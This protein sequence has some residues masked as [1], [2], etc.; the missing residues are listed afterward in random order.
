MTKQLAL[1]ALGLVAAAP[2]HALTEVSDE[3]I[4]AETLVVRW[5]AKRPVDVLVS[6]APDAAASD[7]TLASAAD[8]DGEHRL[9]VPAGQRRYMLLRER[10]TSKTLRVAERL[11]PLEAGSNFRDIGG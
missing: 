10:G 4:D 5:T 1:I 7:A 3:R 8:D 6:D 11:L 2:A 9:G